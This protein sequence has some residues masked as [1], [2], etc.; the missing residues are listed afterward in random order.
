LDQRV[1]N[2]NH[3]RGFA[4]KPPVTACIH[5]QGLTKGNPQSMAKNP[6]LKSKKAKAAIKVLD[7][8]QCLRQLWG[9]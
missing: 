7:Y 8:S 6:S 9:L 1:S 3:K 5:E 4:A 2:R